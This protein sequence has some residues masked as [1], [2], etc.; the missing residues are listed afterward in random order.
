MRGIDLEVGV[1]VVLGMIN[2][3]T[4]H[5]LT[6]GTATSAMALGAM[7]GAALLRALGVED[8]ESLARAAAD[9]VLSPE[10]L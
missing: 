2:V 1:I 9:E 6:S 5:L 7:T 10:V 3:A 4:R 8:A